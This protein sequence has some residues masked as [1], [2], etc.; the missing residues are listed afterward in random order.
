[1]EYDVVYSGE[2]LPTFRRNLLSPS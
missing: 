1:M 2:N